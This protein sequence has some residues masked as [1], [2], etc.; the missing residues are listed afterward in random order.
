MPSQ[1]SPPAK[2]TRS[3]INQDVL[4]PTARA[5]LDCTSSVHQ[6]SANLDRGLPM[7]GAA[8]SR[9]GG[10]KSRRSR[11]FSGLYHERQKEKGSHQ[12]KKTPIIGSNASKP[13][14]DSPRGEEL[15]L[16]YDFHFHLNPIIDW[17]NGLITYDSS[18]KDSIGI[19]SST[20]NDLAT[21]VN[22]VSLVGEL[23]TPS[24]PPSVHIPSIIPSHSLLPSRDE[25]FKEIKYVG[26]A[27]AISSLHFF[28]GAMYLPPL[29]FNSSQKEQW[30]EEEEPEE[31]ETLLN[32]VPPAYH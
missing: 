30:D 5:P 23:K 28:Q 15:I 19:I 17:K 31:I 8:P 22:S 32:V 9:R 27:V 21:A 12:E 3:P 29:S 4:T 13:P 10:V 11:S 25:G 20:R 6:L 24:L 16:G 14:Q 7:E 1:H 2:N 26:E 18:H